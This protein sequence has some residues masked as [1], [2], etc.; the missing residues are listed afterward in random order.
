MNYYDDMQDDY[1]KSLERR[2]LERGPAKS[3]ID[4]FWYLVRLGDPRRLDAWLERHSAPIRAQLRKMKIQREVSNEVPKGAGWVTA[5]KGFWD[6]WRAERAAMV[7]EGYA[8]RNFGGQWFCRQRAASTASV[9]SP[10]P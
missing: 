3:T 6:R 2:R 8:V 5:P 7:L 10:R 9:A 1:E 4:A